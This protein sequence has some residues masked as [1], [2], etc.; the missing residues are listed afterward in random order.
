[1][2]GRTPQGAVQIE[3]R[4]GQVAE[5]YLSRESQAVFAR[6]LDVA[7]STVSADLKAIRKASKASAI[8]DFDETRGIELAWIDKLERESWDAWERSK[9]PQEETKLTN[10]GNGKR[11]Q[12]TTRH[13]VS[14]ARFLD[15]VYKCIGGRRAL[16]GL[17]TPTRIAPTSPDGADSYHSHVMKELMRLAEQASAGPTVVDVQYVKEEVSKLV[18]NKNQ[19]N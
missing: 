2:T 16:L 13:R 8:R 4:R 3:Y 14:D 9:E 19:T 11:A 6:R 18:S 12:K 17:D 5:L 15:I 1:M 10:D 7:Q